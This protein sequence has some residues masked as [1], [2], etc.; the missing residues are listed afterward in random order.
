VLGRNY[1][2]DCCG[3][4]TLSEC[5]FSHTRREGNRVA[6][7]LAQRAMSSCEC[8]VLR[9]DMPPEVRDLVQTDAARIG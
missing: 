6:H 7:Q 2:R 3:Q 5:R 8:K 4:R 9:F 1:R